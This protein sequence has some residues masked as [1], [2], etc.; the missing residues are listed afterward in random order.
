MVLRYAHPTQ[1][2][3]ARSVERLER[4]VAEQRLLLAAKG[5]GPSHMVQSPVAKST[6]ALF[7]GTADSRYKCNISETGDSCI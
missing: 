5:D 1:D 7:R 2:H 4:Y 6:P 3:Q